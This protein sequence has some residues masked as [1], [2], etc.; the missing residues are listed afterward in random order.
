M[1]DKPFVCYIHIFHI[2]VKI[3]GLNMVFAVKINGLNLN[4]SCFFGFIADCRPAMFF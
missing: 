1:R 3:N 2:F 4:Q